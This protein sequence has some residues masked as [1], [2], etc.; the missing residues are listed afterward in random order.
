MV[1]LSC[2]N[3][4][5]SR[6]SGARCGS[7]KQIARLASAD[8]LRVNNLYMN[9]LWTP[10]AMGPRGLHPANA[11]A[12]ENLSGTEPFRFGVREKFGE[13]TDSL[14]GRGSEWSSCLESVTEPRP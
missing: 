6:Y 1:R 13:C 8:T 9:L 2:V 4:P 5:V 7:A 10:G 3:G 11:A 12:A 14:Y